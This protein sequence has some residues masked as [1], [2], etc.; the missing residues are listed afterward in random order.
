MCIDAKLMPLDQAAVTADAVIAQQSAAFAAGDPPKTN[1]KGKGAKGKGKGADGKG[2]GK[3]KGSKGKGKGK[4]SPASAEFVIP[5]DENG[6]VN[7]WVIGMSPCWCK[8]AGLDD[9]A[10]IFEHCKYDENGKLKV[11][12]ANVAA[13]AAGTSAA[14]NADQM[15]ALASFAKKYMDAHPQAGADDTSATQ[16]AKSA[17]VTPPE[18]IESL[19]DDDTVTEQLRQFYALNTE[20]KAAG[21]KVKTVISNIITIFLWSL[22]AL[23]VIAAVVAGL[24]FIACGLPGSNALSQMNS[25]HLEVPVSHYE[26]YPWITWILFKATERLTLVWQYYNLWLGYILHIFKI[27]ARIA[28]T[29]FGIYFF[30]RDLSCAGSHILHALHSAVR[31]LRS[32]PTSTERANRLERTVQSLT[33]ISHTFPRMIGCV[34]LLSG[35]LPGALGHPSLDHPSPS[36]GLCTNVNITGIQHIDLPVRGANYNPFDASATKR[37]D[38]IDEPSI[39][40][41]FLRQ[42][43]SASESAGQT[44]VLTAML[45]AKASKSIAKGISPLTVFHAA[46]D[47]GCTCSCTGYIDRLIN[48]RPCREVYSQAN[49]RL[50]Y[51]HWKGDMPVYVKTSANTTVSMTISNVR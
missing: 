36:H 20:Q 30:R 18:D 12:T 14:S 46:L 43:L 44:A 15:A 7:G 16:H 48:L 10:H 51:C 8:S 1:G 17:V 25:A 34:I 22:V 11:K 49:G 4:G 40:T 21:T 26:A 35:L 13:A 32:A 31:P 41:A 37:V 47:S 42:Q 27:N 6:K 28:L 9:G 24:H 19:M 3:G 2:A 50:S 5:R 29:L 23:T 38:N 33:R 45:T 39:H